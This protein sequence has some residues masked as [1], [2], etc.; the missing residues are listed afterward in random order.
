[1]TEARIAASWLSPLLALIARLDDLAAN[2]PDYVPKITQGIERRGAKARRV[3]VNGIVYPKMTLV[4]IEYVMSPASVTFRCNSD[5]YP[6]WFY[7]DPP[8]KTSSPEED[9]DLEEE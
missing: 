9:D 5:L 8:R 7:L 6:N 2:P 3:S 4:A 1:M